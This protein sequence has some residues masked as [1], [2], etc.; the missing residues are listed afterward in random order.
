MHAIRRDYTTP[1]G[2]PAA[3]TASGMVTVMVE[4]QIGQWDH[5]WRAFCPLVIVKQCYGPHRDR[6]RAGRL[7]SMKTAAKLSFSVTALK[8]STF[9]ETAVT[10]GR[11][12]FTCGSHA[13]YVCQGC[14]A[15]CIS[16]IGPIEWRLV[17]SSAVVFTHLSLRPS[18]VPTASVASFDYH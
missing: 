14:Q 11:N 9:Y 2:F 12:G 1:T 8:F 3:P 17:N 15:A 16:C 6:R 18:T 10:V 4:K 13:L 5:V 7:R